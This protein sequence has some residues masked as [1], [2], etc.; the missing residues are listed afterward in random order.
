MTIQEPFEHIE[1]ARI[2]LLQAAQEVDRE[3]FLNR[4]KGMSSIR[5]LLVH[6]MDAEDYWI[7]SVVCGEKRQKFL[8]E[9]YEDVAALQANWD[10]IHGRTQKLVSDIA[11]GLL[12]EQTTVRWEGERVLDLGTVFLHVF[13][14]ELHHRG[15]ICLLMRQQG[16]EPPYVDLL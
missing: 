16:Y 4:Q 10:R 13:T 14:H 9:K 6:L 5:D 8:P 1:N 15:Q 12:S 3:C 2:L 11:S 7:G